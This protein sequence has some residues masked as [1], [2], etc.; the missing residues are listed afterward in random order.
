MTE[1]ISD[2]EQKELQDLVQRIATHIVEGSSAVHELRGTVA[3]LK[4]Q[5]SDLEFIVA[6]NWLAASK[7]IQ[8]AGKNIT[9]WEN[10][11]NALRITYTDDL[12]TSN[13]KL[14]K[15]YDKLLKKSS[16]ELWKQ[17]ITTHEKSTIKGE[18]SI[19]PEITVHEESIHPTPNSLHPYEAS[20]EFNVLEYNVS[21]SNLHPQTGIGKVIFL[22][23]EIFD[24]FGL[25]L[26]NTHY[27]QF[28]T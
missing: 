27:F 15:E 23:M 11:I 9:S 2:A 3:K 21:N 8:E 14:S 16:E 20:T 22:F 18:T 17:E 12:E 10:F 7:I 26:Y 1:E 4:N 24:H 19:S 5:R 13:P 28:F 25:L 6:Q